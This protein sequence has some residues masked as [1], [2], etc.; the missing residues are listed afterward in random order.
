MDRTY[1]SILVL[2]EM[3]LKPSFVQ[4]LAIAGVLICHSENGWREDDMGYSNLL[5][6]AAYPNLAAM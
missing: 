4:H 1:L 6:S 3:E 5:F 2:L